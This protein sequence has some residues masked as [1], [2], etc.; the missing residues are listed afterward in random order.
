M[1]TVYSLAFAF[2]LLTG[3]AAQLTTI[4]Y[5]DA[6]CNTETGRESVALGCKSGGSTSANVACSGGQATISA[7]ASTG[8]TGTK[9]DTVIQLDTC[10]AQRRNVCSSGSSAAL[11]LLSVAAAAFVVSL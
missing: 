4:S 11:A 3:I 6:A 1:K 8:C 5:S 9:I 10:I 2:V 7:Y